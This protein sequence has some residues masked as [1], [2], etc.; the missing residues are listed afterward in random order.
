MKRH[1]IIGASAAGMGVLNQL[2]TLDPESTIICIA[3][4]SAWPYNT[5]FLADY[6][7][8]S[9]ELAQLTLKHEDFFE[10]QRITLRL[11]TE[12][13]RIDK[14]TK[15]ISLA[16]GE[17]LTYDTL[18]LGLGARARKLALEG[19]NDCSDIFYFHTYA[20]ARAIKEHITANKIKHAVV[21]GAGLSGL[22]IADSL[23]KNGIS[24]TVVEQSVE[25]LPH[26]ADMD[27]SQL[28]KCLAQSHNTTIMSNACVARVVTQNNHMTAVELTDGQFIKADML[29]IAIGSL[30]NS[31]LA[32]NAGVATQQGAIITNEFLQTNDPAIY[33]G[34]DVAQVIERVSGLL[35]RNGAWPDAMHQGLIAAHGM[36]GIQKSYPGAVNILSS[37]FFGVH[38][39]SCGPVAYANNAYQV[40]VIK[41][42]D[43]YH[44]FLFD[45]EI[46]KGFLLIGNTQ[47]AAEYRKFYLAQVPAPLF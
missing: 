42:S 18:F 15:T 44:K 10:K 7:S 31:E 32:V 43:F 5:C 8:G 41:G 9:K 33:A 39:F 46:L 28:L 17:Q 26:H 36:A 6:L 24:V 21:I 1:I 22:E 19:S 35:V 27:G 40:K 45:G 3:K 12:V 16:T 4:E 34:G 47:K 29:V 38:F 30:P 37:A 23:N 11:A 25:I 13:T 14:S 20:D 2:R